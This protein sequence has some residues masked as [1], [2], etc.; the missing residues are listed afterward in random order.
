MVDY[1]PEGG[2]NGRVRADRASRISRLLRS[3][4]HDNRHTCTLEAKPRPDGYAPFVQI[5]S[6][7]QPFAA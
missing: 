5:P 2:R 7:P 1:A 4:S 3:I 6:L